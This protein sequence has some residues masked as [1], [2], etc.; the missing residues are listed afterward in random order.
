MILGDAVQNLRSAL[1]HLAQQLYLV[2]TGGSAGYRDKTSFFIAPKASEYKR[3]VSGKVEGMRKDAIDALSALEPYNGGK[4]HD[5]WILHR[6]NNI[7]KH[8]TIVAAG[9]SY[10]SVDVGSLITRRIART[11]EEMFP[12][13]KFPAISLGLR[14]A[15]NL[16]PLKKG[17]VLFIGLVDGEID[18]QMKFTFD[19]AL[20][21]PEVVKP[22]P[23]LEI[24]QHLADLVSNTVTIFKPCLA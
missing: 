13:T 6:L 12:G 7:D 8:R 21:E 11:H 9:S 4:G 15:D 16:C 2:G 20:Y 1:D 3:H 5:F 14:P 24:V 17:D 19:V 22:G 10:Q 23:M 18:E